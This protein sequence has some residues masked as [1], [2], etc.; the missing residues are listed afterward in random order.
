MGLSVRPTRYPRCKV[1]EG[2]GE[3]VGIAPREVGDSSRP[4]GAV[5]VA[6]LTRAETAG[7]SSKYF[8]LSCKSRGALGAQRVARRGGAAP[9]IR[10]AAS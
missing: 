8:R 7:A 3:K 1:E 9:E 5:K 10:F 2:A 6:A 4:A